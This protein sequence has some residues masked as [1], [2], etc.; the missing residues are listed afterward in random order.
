MFPFERVSPGLRH[1]IAGGALALVKFDVDL[2]PA[3]ARR[4]ITIASVSARSGDGRARLRMSS[5]DLI[6]MRPRES[7]V[8]LIEPSCAASTSSSSSTSISPVSKIS[9][10]F[11]VS[12]RL[13]RWR[14]LVFRSVLAPLWSVGRGDTPVT[15]GGGDH[16]VG[17]D[18]DAQPVV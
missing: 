5:F 15:S 3:G 8:R 11:P 10:K 4:D 13:E 14:T 9:R 1:E 17:P 2:R 7:T 12:P 16:R 6:L 18:E